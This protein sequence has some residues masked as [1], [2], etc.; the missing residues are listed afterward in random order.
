[1]LRITTDEMA[2]E[3]INQEPKMKE[4]R[5]ATLDPEMA[6]GAVIKVVGVGGG[7]CNAVDW[8]IQKGLKGVEYIAINTDTQSLQARRSDLKL[9]IGYRITQGLGTGCDP[10]LG[11]KC[12]NEDKEKIEQVLEGANMVF[13]TTGLGGGTGSGAAPV[14]CAIARKLDILTVGIVTKPFDHEGK[15]KKLIAEKSIQEMRQYCDSL[16]IIPNDKVSGLVDE[17]TSF[18]SAFY[19]PNQVLYESVKGISDIITLTGEINVDFADVRRVMKNSGVALMGT[20]VATGDN[21]M[22][23]AATAAISS[24]LLD[25][26]SLQ[27]AKNI[28]IHIIAPMNVGMQEITKANQTIQKEAGEEANLIWGVVRDSSMNDYVSYTVIATGFNSAVKPAVKPIEQTTIHG[29]PANVRDIPATPKRIS[30]ANSLPYDAEDYDSPAY[31]RLMKRKSQ[32][33]AKAADPDDRQLDLNLKDQVK[34]TTDMYEQKTAQ[35]EMSDSASSDFLR[36]MMD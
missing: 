6:R 17:E 33:Q 24:P 5:F 21:R 29:K 31:I 16:I 25:G 20:G 9:A 14:V 27:G 36:L 32:M 15:E 34:K 4:K 13:V 11:K 7:G 3:I 2:S 30:Q 28:L 1:M 23:Q 18:D 8:M 22:I 19:R 26:I 35:A 10:E 12:A